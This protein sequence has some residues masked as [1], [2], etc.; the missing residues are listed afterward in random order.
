MASGQRAFVR[1]TTAET[2]TAILREEPADI[3]AS[4]EAPPPELAGTVR[5][6]L[7]KRAQSRF[8]S[9]SDL[10]YNLRTIS[11]AS[12]PS[13]IGERRRPAGRRKWAPWT[14]VA[15]VL[16]AVVAIVLW[17][18]RTKPAAEI[19]PDQPKRIVVLPFDNLGSADDAYFASGIT[20]E[21]TS[22][23]AAV[24]GLQVISRSSARRY[25]DTDKSIREIGEE[26]EVGY[27]LE[28][29]IR[30]DREVEDHGRVRVTPQLI[31][32]ADD[33]HLWSERY[34]R[35]LDDIFA[36]QSEIAEAVVGQLGVALL[37][38][39]QR[40]VAARPTESLEAHQAYLRGLEYYWDPD[41]T[42]ES[43]E[44][45]VRMFERAVDHD[46]AFVAAHALLSESHSVLYHL[47]YD[48]SPERLEA[49]RE[50][51]FRALELDPDSPEGHRA[52]GSYHYYGH[53]DYQQALEEYS[54]AAK[55]LPNDSLIVAE[56]GWVRR[57]Q[58]RFDEAIAGL[59]KALELDPRNA[60][61]ASELADTYRFVRQYPEADRYYDLS[62]SLAPDQVEG[63][64]RKAFNH[65]AW[66]GSL[67]LARATLESIPPGL[68]DP[69][70]FSWWVRLEW[71]ERD[72]QAALDRLA[73]AP[74]GVFVGR[75]SGW[76]P[77][78]QGALYSLLNQPERARA[79]YEAARVV[80]EKRAKETPQDRVTRGLLGFVYAGLGRKA[81]AISEVQAAVKLLPVS[82]DAFAGVG[83]V[84]FLAM[85]YTMVGEHDAAI[86]QLEYLLSIPSWWSA[87]NLRLNPGWDPLRDHPRFQVLLEK[88]E[89][90]EPV[91]E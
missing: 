73:A 42:K 67:G 3:S 12:A 1:D 43:C 77:R 76:K 41:L 91:G 2:M 56:I 26:L 35:V 54:L 5:R 36:V 65:I 22:R 79:S 84:W 58:G 52:L 38:D 31:R 4:G 72:Y 32:V 50:A 78:V 24:S 44:L 7:E 17:Q 59:E 11:S 40:A 86:D 83:P 69:Q 19:L 46:P 82:K 30:W 53:R 75:W 70:Y 81:D 89:E 47:W 45:A 13:V 27:V 23:L 61:L 62:I 18:T 85:V 90:Q 80:L 8:Q 48:R 57:R 20:E 39:E 87:W 68:E 29:T 55:R 64:T 33:S 60:Y 28:G 63:Y 66:E 34:D 10:A 49:A 74:D 9:A 37:P 14:A 21:I 16:V 88:Y 71:H 15:A 51:A 25:S 6:C